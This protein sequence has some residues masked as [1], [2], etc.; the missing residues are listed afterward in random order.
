MIGKASSL[1]IIAILFCAGVQAATMSYYCHVL[2]KAINETP[3]IQGK[4]IS[5]AMPIA[6]VSKL[7]TSYWAIKTLGP[8]YRFITIL[9]IKKVGE[10]LY[11]IHLEGSRDPYFG[12]ESL[13]YLI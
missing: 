2:D 9:H 7:V 1:F 3:T 12:K 10:D 4:N 6:S 5:K 8:D 11:D 13:H